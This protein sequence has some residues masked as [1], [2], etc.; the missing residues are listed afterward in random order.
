MYF[1]RTT[2]SAQTLQKRS[3]GFT[4]I[5]LMVVVA[6]IGILAAIAVPQY[7]DYTARTQMTRAVGE[8]SAYKTGVEDHLLR[9]VTTI[10]NSDLGYVQSN[11]TIEYKPA[12]TTLWTYDSTAKTGKLAV[13]MGQNASTAVSGTVVTLSRDATGTW[14]CAIVGAKTGGWKDSYKPAI[15]A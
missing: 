7:Q 5:E 13:T 12:G 6:I 10:V 15:C 4:M 14:T 3:K 8:L 2:R 11:I 9:G 1:S